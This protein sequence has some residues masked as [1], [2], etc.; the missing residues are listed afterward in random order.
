MNSVE[1]QL[2]YMSLLVHST[3][4]TRRP[5]RMSQHMTTLY[6]V[7]WACATWPNSVISWLNDRTGVHFE[8]HLENHVK[9]WGAIYQYTS[10]SVHN[11]NWKLLTLLSRSK[12]YESSSLW[13][14]SQSE[15]ISPIYLKAKYELTFT[16]TKLQ[17]H[18]WKYWKYAHFKMLPLA[19]KAQ[20]A[21]EVT[22]P[23]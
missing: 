1:R 10:V 13:S 22:T 12:R 6:T 2:P 5:L 9:R 21:N 20:I 17:V 4:S 19:F 11:W 8:K 3:H 18:I 16:I 14:A 7:W 23:T 15:I